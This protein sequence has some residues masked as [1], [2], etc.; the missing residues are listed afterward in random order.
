MKAK[1][2]SGK[3]FAALANKTSPALAAYIGRKKYGAQKFAALGAAGRARN[4][5]HQLTSH[6][7][8]GSNQSHVP[9]AN[10]KITSHG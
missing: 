4:R 3:R 1:L 2:G 5:P 10:Q 7:H 6:G 9:P 8:K